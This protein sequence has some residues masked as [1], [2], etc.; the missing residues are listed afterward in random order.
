M[1][2]P[3]WRLTA[4]YIPFINLSATGKMDFKQWIN[5]KW[6]WMQF[7]EK[8]F[9]QQLEEFKDVLIAFQGWRSEWKR[10]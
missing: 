3:V 5:I 8:K 1:K 9:C 2:L 10:G 7:G 6:R 4:T